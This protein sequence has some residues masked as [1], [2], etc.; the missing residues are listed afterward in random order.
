MIRFDLATRKTELI[1]CLTDNGLTS[2]GDLCFVDGYLYVSCLDNMIAKINMSTNTIEKLKIKNSPVLDG[3]YG[4]TY[5][6]DGYLYI[7]NNMGEIHRVDLNT[8]IASYYSTIYALPTSL[9]SDLRATLIC[10]M[11]PG[12]RQK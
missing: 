10:V 3:P 11:H 5:L 6:G 8:M 1:V 4:M 2:A 12:V 7:S 9:L